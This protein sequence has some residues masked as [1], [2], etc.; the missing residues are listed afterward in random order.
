MYYTTE[1]RR[2]TI[3]EAAICRRANSAISHCFLWLFSHDSTVLIPEKN[4]TALR[5]QT[6]QK[7]SETIN[8]E[9]MKYFYRLQY[10]LHFYYKLDIVS[11]TYPKWNNSLKHLLL[12]WTFANDS[13]LTTTLQS[14]H[15]HWVSHGKS[16]TSARTMLDVAPCLSWL[17]RLVLLLCS[18]C[19]LRF[20]NSSSFNNWSWLAFIRRIFCTET[21]ITI[22]AKLTYQKYTLLRLAERL[23]L[24]LIII[25]IFPF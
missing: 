15:I 8:L 14:T 20:D 24:V 22:I 11:Q 23:P 12:L 21:L 2:V 5:A 13:L 18:I 6:L 7:I 10:E 3:T 17:W 19:R 4:W 16:Q 25:V 9:S 1:N